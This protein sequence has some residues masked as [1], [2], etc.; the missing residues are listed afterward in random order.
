MLSRANAWWAG[1]APSAFDTPSFATG[2]SVVNTDTSVTTSAP[3]SG[4]AGNRV[5]V[6]AGHTR[7]S[8]GSPSS[9]IR[10]LS[11]ISGSDDFSGLSLGDWT[12]HED[13][14]SLISGG[15]AGIRLIA[16]SY[17]LLGAATGTITVT[18]SSSAWTQFLMVTVLPACSVIDSDD[19]TA[20]GT[21]SSVSIDFT[22]TILPNDLILSLGAQLLTNDITIP[23]SH[24]TTGTINLA[25]ARF[26][27]S[28]KNG[29]PADPTTWTGLYTSSSIP[30]AAIGIILRRTG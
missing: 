13:A 12:S 20:N 2:T 14:S 15:S 4:V 28:Y 29:T 23:T 26:R 3:V 1:R 5:M 27:G 25:N 7:G 10:T 9:A 16:R 18:W 17:V 19:G 22:E 8:I 30:K 6:V 21:E 24:T 11:N